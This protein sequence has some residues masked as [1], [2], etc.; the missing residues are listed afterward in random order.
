MSGEGKQLDHVYGNGGKGGGGDAWEFMRNELA[1]LRKGFEACSASLKA[2]ETDA[3]RYRWLRANP[4]MAE[5][6]FSRVVVKPGADILAQV[7]ELVD[8]LSYADMRE[9]EDGRTPGD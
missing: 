8:A 7:D 1:E 9:A 6:V 4:I 3:A 5:T 2:A